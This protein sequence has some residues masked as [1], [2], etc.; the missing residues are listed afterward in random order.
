M[1]KASLEV[2]RGDA[3][4]QPVQVV[5]PKGHELA[6]QP[7]DLTGYTARA[8]VRHRASDADPLLALTIDFGDRTA[9]EVFVRAEASQTQ[10]LAVG[11]HV[12]DLEL[13][14]N[15]KPTTPVGGSFRVI[16]DVT[17]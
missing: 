9:G 11:G 14:I 16:A 1:Q 2:V 15:D 8:Q 3:I 4:D 17:R 10:N 12:W 13:V 7:V 5:Y 6:G